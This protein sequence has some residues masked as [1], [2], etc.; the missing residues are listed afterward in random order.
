MR[1]DDILGDGQPQS[2]P[3]CASFRG[4]KGLQDLVFDVGRNARTVVFDLDGDRCGRAL[5]PED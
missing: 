5:G 2:R 4:E 3:L 1:L